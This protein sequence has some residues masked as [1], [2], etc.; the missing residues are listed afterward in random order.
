[1][2]FGFKLVGDN[3]DKTVKPRDMRQDHTSQSLHYFNVYA[4]RD[5]IDFSSLSCDSAV[6][7]TNDIDIGQFLPSVAEE[8]ALLHYFCTLIFR[9]LCQHIPALYE[10]S[11]CL[12]DHID[13]KYSKETST[14]SQVVSMIIIQ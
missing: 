13:H 11:S 12:V 8:E 4:V 2:N 3:L 1:M 5:R 9:L 14:K 6:N 10:Y 7:D